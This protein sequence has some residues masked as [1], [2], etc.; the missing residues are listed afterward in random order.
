MQ[1]Q[2]LFK[3]SASG[4]LQATSVHSPPRST[5]LGSSKLLE[6]PFWTP[7][8][9]HVEAAG[10]IV[11]CTTNLIRRSPRL[12]AWISGRRLQCQEDLEVLVL[13]PFIRS[14]HSFSVSGT[15]KNLAPHGFG[16]SLGLRLR[17][18][19]LGHTWGFKAS[20]SCL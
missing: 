6:E 13:E 20:V 18:K 12:Q 11:P 15:R 3:P 9:L 16:F 14:S 1:A 2:G 17:P 7:R 5:P 8:L 4:W 19:D 10:V